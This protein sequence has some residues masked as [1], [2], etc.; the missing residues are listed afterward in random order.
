MA[1]LLGSLVAYDP[2]NNPDLGVLAKGDCWRF[3]L[4]HLND[5]GLDATLEEIG[6]HYMVHGTLGTA[7]LSELLMAHL[8]VVPPEPL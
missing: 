5:E 8:D 1:K 6:S 2:V 3:V 4:D 7:P